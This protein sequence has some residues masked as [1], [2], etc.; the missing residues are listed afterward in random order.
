MIT[1]LAEIRPHA[2]RKQADRAALVVENRR[3]S[4]RELD[5]LTN[6]VAPTGSLRFYY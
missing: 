5:A 4:F 1:M 6:R 2:A 3:F